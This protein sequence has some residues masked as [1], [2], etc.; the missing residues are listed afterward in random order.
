ML[1]VETALA[2]VLTTL[3]EPGLLTLS[4][5]IGALSW[6]PARVSGLDRRRS[7]RAYRARSASRTSA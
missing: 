3:V 4:E 1:G 6:R 5:A 7:R 2:V